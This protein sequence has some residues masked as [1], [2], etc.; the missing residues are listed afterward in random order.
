M[1]DQTVFDDTTK[2]IIPPTTPVTT[3]TDPFVDKL[4]LIKNEK[5][6]PK[7]KTVDD[8]LVA[9]YNSQE[10]IETLKTEK[11][12]LEEQF[13]IVKA[14]KDKLGSIDDFVQRLNPNAKPT[15]PPATPAKEDGLS[16]ERVAQ[17]LETT[18]Q[19]REREALMQ[20]N[21]NTVVG[22]L[23][24]THGDKTKD[25]IRKRAEELS[26]TPA[27]LKELA[28]SNPTMAMTLLSGASIKQAPTP[29]QPSIVKPS[30]DLT[31]PNPRPLAEQ[32]KGITRGGLSNKELAER[33]K[34]SKE[35][36]NKRIG[37]EA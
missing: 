31:D 13:Q 25:F 29:S 1:S 34:K 36:T 2:P 28:M 20:Q 3:Q 32:G 30:Q 14:E 18:L 26:T 35:F 15:Q 9:L 10:F 24:Q 22:Q 21:L 16:E 37:L 12:Q 19:K 27:A 6:E 4:M 23:A 7:Y 11:R 17:L 33:F 5:G 8:A